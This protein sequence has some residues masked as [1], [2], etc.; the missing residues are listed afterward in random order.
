MNAPRDAVFNALAD[1]ETYP[2]WLVGAQQ[3]RGVDKDF[4]EPGSEFQHSVGPTEATTIDDSTKTLESHGHRQLIL[5]AHA[6]PMKAEVEFD[7]V[8]R[9]DDRTEV[10]MRERPLGAASVL[11][12]LIRPLLALRNMRSM[13]QFAA[14]VERA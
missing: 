8:K 9:G 11:T 1:P 2:E 7:L 4:P 6:G 14:F 12:P 5:E 10:V 13:H 3:I